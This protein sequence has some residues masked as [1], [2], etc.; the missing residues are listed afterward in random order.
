MTEET[1][2]VLFDVDGTMAHYKGWADGKIGALLPGVRET[3]RA[4]RKAGNRVLIWTA[5]GDV[6][7]VRKWLAENGIEHDGFFPAKKP[8][9][10]ILIVDDRAYRAGNMG[11]DAERVLAS[12]KP[13]WKIQKEARS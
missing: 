1:G 10:L 7:Y 13:A 4:L 6:E 2:T 5:R 9:D 12:I 3:V 8:I 11:L